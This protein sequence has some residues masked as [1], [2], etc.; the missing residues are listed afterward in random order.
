MRRERGP[1]MKF[2]IRDGRKVEGREVHRL[3]SESETRNAFRVSG[4]SGDGGNVEQS[5]AEGCLMD[6]EWRS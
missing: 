6:H 5:W 4:P 1:R 3:D 2:E